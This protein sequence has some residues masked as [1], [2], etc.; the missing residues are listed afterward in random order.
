MASSVWASQAGPHPVTPRVA[1]P[2]LAL[3]VLAVLV[4]LAH[5]VVL[6]MPAARIGPPPDPA[7]KRVPAFAT[8]SIPLPPPAAPTIAAPATPAT[9]AKP[10]RPPRPKP[11]FKEKSAFPQDTPGLAAIESIA[12]PVQEPQIAEA[13]PVP[14]GMDSAPPAAAGAAEAMATAEAVAPTEPAA[15]AADT[16]TAAAAPA[17]ASAAPPSGASQTPITAMAL[18]ASAQLDYKMTGSAKGLTYH[19]N[20]E[21]AWQN[22]GSSYNARMTVKALFIGSRTMRSTGQI[23][24]TGLAPNRFSDKSRTEVAAHFEPDKGQISFSANTPAVPW[25]QGSQDR[26]SVFLQLGGMLAGNPAAFPVGSSISMLTVGP[27]DADNWT[28]VVESEDQ[29]SLPFGDLAT[30]KLSRKPRREYDQ[31]VE[32]WYAPALGYLPVRNKI[33]QS[34]GDFVDQQLSSL[35][36]P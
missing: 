28:F 24:D 17:S 8:R 11:V 10:A 4:L 1:P 27:R 29:L 19:A 34:N 36:R 26:V 12:K 7:L 35:T 32:I 18:P 6:Q 16:A 9:P 15:T 5:A 14:A 21:L 20:G 30:V 25:A 2:R 23:S 31:K 22:S 13:D 3:A 33:T